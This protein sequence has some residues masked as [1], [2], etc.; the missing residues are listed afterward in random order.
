MRPCGGD[1]PHSIVVSAPLGVFVDI[2]VIK[3]A[4]SRLLASGCGDLIANTIAVLDWKLGHE[5]TG[6]Y[7]GIYS[8]NL[9]RMSANIVME[10]AEA[11]A[12]NGIDA[13]VV[14]EALISAGVASCIAG[15]SRPCSGAEH[16]F[17]HALDRI[18]PGRAGA[19][20]R[21]VRSGFNNDGQAA[22]PGL[23]GDRRR[24]GGDRSPGHRRAGGA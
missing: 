6:E 18:A 20:R 12:Q 17:S 14:V 22:R 10:N 4:P 8:A 5:R 1:R 9:A 11:F 24:T 21:K 3:R 7:Y 13:R 2:D 19:A 23:E 15:S 16:L